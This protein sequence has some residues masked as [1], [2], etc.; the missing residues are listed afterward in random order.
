MDHIPVLLKETIA[1]LDPKPNENFIDCTFGRGGHSLAILEKTA[2]EGIVLGIER[3]KESIATLPQ[4]IQKNSRLTVINDSY[5]NIGG[6]AR[7]NDFKRIKGILLDLGMSSWHLDESGKGFSFSKDEPL[8]MR[9]DSVAGITA[10]QI[11]NQ[12]SQDELEKIFRDFGQEK[13]AKKIAVAIVA[14][15]RKKEIATARDLSEIVRGLPRSRSRASIA[16][17]F[18]SLRI[19]VNDELGNTRKGIAAAFGMLETGGRIA[20]ISFHSLEDKIVKEE[21]KKLVGQGKARLLFKKP[22]VPRPEEI[23][24]NPRCASA[25]LRA[26][27][28]IA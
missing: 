3:D 28:K 26:I 17:I 9:Y 25:K 7:K 23:A 2:P 18:Q 16:R 12:Y 24:A 4:N 5:A 21:F 6:I 10:K 11:V 13:N 27:E 14:G 22:I 15:R 1:A 20:A 19:A 8:D